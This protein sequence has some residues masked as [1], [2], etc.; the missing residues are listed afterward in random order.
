M[1]HRSSRTSTSTRSRAASLQGDG[2]REILVPA[3]PVKFENLDSGIAS[4][5]RGPRLGEHS[6]EILQQYGYS[7]E[8]VD[9][10]IARGI[11]SSG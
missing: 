5:K 6:R 9:T 4:Q 8:E 2:R 11:T 1:T 7:N 10:F 3:N